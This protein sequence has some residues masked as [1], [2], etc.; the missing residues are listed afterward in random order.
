VAVLQHGFGMIEKLGGIR[1][2]QSHVATLTEYLFGRMSNLRHS[3]GKPMLQIFGKH[4]FAN[5]RQVRM[6]MLGCVGLCRHDQGPLESASYE[7]SGGLR[8]SWDSDRAE[9]HA[10]LH[11]GSS[12]PTTCACVHLSLHS[13]IVTHSE[14]ATLTVLRSFI[15]ASAV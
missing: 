4:H 8:D 12:V 11:A 6:R 15:A 2:I 5:S 3:N 9:V 10:V 7:H 13:S 1:N 14:I